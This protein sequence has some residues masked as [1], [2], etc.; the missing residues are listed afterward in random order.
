MVFPMMGYLISLHV[1]ANPD[2][3]SPALKIGALDPKLEKQV[4]ARLEPGMSLLPIWRGFN[5]PAGQQS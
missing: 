5:P 2:G 3:L 1:I 4:S